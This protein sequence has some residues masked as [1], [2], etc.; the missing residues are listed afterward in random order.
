[1]L[2]WK[3]FITVD[4]G[5]VKELLDEYPIKQDTNIVLRTYS[6]KLHEKLY[7]TMNLVEFIKDSIKNYVL[8]PKLLETL[9]KKGLD[10][11]QEALK[12]FGDIDPSSD[13]KYGK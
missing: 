1:M 11:F 2:E 10:P 13:G 9:K 6:V 12:Y 8:S 4:E 7:D 3:K 5:W